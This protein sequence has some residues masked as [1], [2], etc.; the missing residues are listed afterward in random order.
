MKQGRPLSIWL[1]DE[2]IEHL[3][4]KSKKEKRSVSNFVK[5]ELFKEKK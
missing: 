2:E 5:C 3:K 1:S 4:K